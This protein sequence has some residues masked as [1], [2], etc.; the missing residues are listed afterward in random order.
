MLISHPNQQKKTEISSNIIIIKGIAKGS[1]TLTKNQTTKSPLV[2][3]SDTYATIPDN[4]SLFGNFNDTTLCLAD[5]KPQ[6]SLSNTNLDQNLSKRKILEFINNQFFTYANTKWSLNLRKEVFSPNEK[7]ETPS[8]IDLIFMQIIRDFNSNDCV[9][10][11]EVDRQKLVEF[12][13]S[14]DLSVSFLYEQYKSFKIKFKKQ[15]IEMAKDF[16]PLYFCRLFPIDGYN[17]LEMLAVS[18]A[19]VKL[20]NREKNS[21]NENLIPTEQYR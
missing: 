16:W 1:S 12:L 2:L 14:R 11:S 8:A 3:S 20:V 9:R 10:I 19:G 18:H 7:L 6:H 4:D 17:D 13:E 15:L 21:L 5:S